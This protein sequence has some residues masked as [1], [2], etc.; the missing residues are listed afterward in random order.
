VCIRAYIKNQLIYYIH[1][2]GR[3]EIKA[4]DDPDFRMSIDQIELR[5]KIPLLDLPWGDGKD[6]TVVDLWEDYDEDLLDA[7]YRKYMTTQFGTSDGM[8]NRGSEGTS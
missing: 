6:W 3:T 5:E 1:L 7:F 8:F 4:Q 2:A